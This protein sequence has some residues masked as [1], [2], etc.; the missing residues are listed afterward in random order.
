MG[1]RAATPL[2]PRTTSPRRRRIAS[3]L[4]IALS[5]LILAACGGQAVATPTPPPQTDEPPAPTQAASPT[6][7]TA[8]IEPPPNAEA[9]PPTKPTVEAPIEPPGPSDAD[10]RAQQ[11]ADTLAAAGIKPAAPGQRTVVVDPGHGGIDGGAAANGVAELSSNLDFALRVENIL[12]ANGYNVVLTRR[13]NGPSLLSPE[14]LSADFTS[15]RPDREARTQLARTVSADIYVSIHSNGHP[16]PTVNGIEA[17]YHPSALDPGQNR[18]FGELVVGRVFAELH[19][20]GYPANSLGAKDDTCWR[21]FGGVCRSIYVL[22]PPLTLSRESLENRGYDPEV[23][24]F[25]P[26]QNYRSTR[27]TAMPAVLVELLFTSNANDAAALRNGALRQAM[28]R[29]V[30]QGVIDMLDSLPQVP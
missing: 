22:S 3:G 11:L 9:D 5:A 12:L 27:G 25:E 7:T 1:I 24:G 13:D 18:R 26:G 17:W 2:R 23:A 15:T 21:Q 29:G 30:A 10:L 20:S 16:D 4:V 28:A 14:I 19:A 6:P 8:A